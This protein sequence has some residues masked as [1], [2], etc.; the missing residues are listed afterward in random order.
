MNGDRAAWADFLNPDLVRSKFVSAGLFLVAHEMLLGSIKRHPLFFCSNTW[1]VNGPEQSE[2][3]R[4]EVLAL[5]PKG[6]SDTLRGSIAWLRHMDAINDEDEQAIKRVTDERNQLAH[7]LSAMIGGSTP[8]SFLE[9]FPTVV[10]LVSKIE[11]WWII[12]VELE[13]DPD[14]AG[15]EFDPDQVVPGVVVS[16]DMLS[17]VALGEGEA[18]WE[19]HRWLESEWPQLT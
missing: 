10:S 9:H 4:R 11:K 1:T 13:T 5:D 17:R 16:L 14:L 12:N 19:L 6:K 8:P 3:Y 7:E 15:Q 18:A 2:E